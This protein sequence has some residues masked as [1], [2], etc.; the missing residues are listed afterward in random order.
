MGKRLGG[1]LMNM[2]AVL[3]M[4][5]PACDSLAQQKVQFS[6]YM[7]NNVVINP[8]YTGADEALSLTFIHRSQWTGVE[9]SP[10]TQTL[11]AHTLFMEKHMGLGLTLINDQIGVHKNLDAMANYAYHL[12]T[13]D[14][15]YLS[16]GLQAGVHNRRSDYASLIGGANNDPKLFNSMISHTFIDFGMGVYFRSPRFHWGVSAPELIP[17]R[18]TVNDTLSLQ[19][20]KVNLFIFSRYRIPLNENTDL[21]PSTLIKYMAGVPVS[22]DLNMN[23]VFRKVLTL[24]LSY[25]KRES[26]D[27]L[28]K[29]QLTPQLQ[30]GYAYDYP[31]GEISRLSR[32]SHEVMVN[33]LFRYVKSNVRS[34]R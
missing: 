4:V 17:E 29:C 33:Y 19:M 24:G 12:K 13:G 32:A 2:G 23:F 11:S 31:V 21:E 20:S 9:K 16:M 28:L 3:L 1:V 7:F 18:I 15:S 10:K 34:P 26:V 6:Q 30:F 5:V 8:A 14:Q 25:R 22:F 27:F